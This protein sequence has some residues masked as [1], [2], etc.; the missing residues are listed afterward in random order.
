MRCCN[1]TPS[2]TTAAFVKKASQSKSKDYS[3][4]HHTPGLQNKE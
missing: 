1:G 3:W 4:E 2:Y